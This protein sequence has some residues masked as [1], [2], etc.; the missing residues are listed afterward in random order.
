MASTAQTRIS[1]VLDERGMTLSEWARRSGVARQTLHLWVHGLQQAQRADKLK[2]AAD[3]V[4]LSVAELRDLLSRA[5]RRSS[6]KARA[7]PS[8]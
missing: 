3:A 6:R 4:G 1:D 5:Q 2:A 7:R 8:A